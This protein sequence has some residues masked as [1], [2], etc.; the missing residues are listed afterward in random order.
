MC[1]KEQRFGK[2]V[3]IIGEIKARLGGLAIVRYIYH[4]K[5]VRHEPNVACFMLCEKWFSKNA[6]G[7][8]YSFDE[9]NSGFNFSK[10]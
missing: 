5:Q 3:K 9:S 6:G 8:F 7:V 10:K 4:H 1:S 2:L